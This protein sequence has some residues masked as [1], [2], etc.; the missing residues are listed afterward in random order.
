MKKINY[1]APTEDDYHQ[2]DNRTHVY[3]KAGM[4]IGSTSKE[5]RDEFVFSDKLNK[6][7]LKTIQFPVGAE[8]V[9]L[10]ILSNACDNC[11]KTMRAGIDC[12]QIEVTMN[13][14]TVIV[15]NYG[16][17]IPIVIKNGVN[18]YIPEFI[19][20]TVLCGSNLKNDNRKDIGTN[21]IGSKATNIMS[22]RFKV[23]IENAEY[24]KRYT[25]IWENNMLICNK[26][27]IEPYNGK[28]S[29]TEI[30]YDLDFK[31]FKYKKYPEEAFELFKKHTID[32]SF[33]GKVPVT[34]NNVQY[35]VSDIYDYG[36]LY[37]AV[38]N[39]IVYQKINDNELELEL[40]V[41]DS[42]DEGFDVAFV[43]CMYTS[44]GGVHLDAAYKAISD[45]LIKLINEK[46]LKKMDKNLTEKEKKSNLVTINDIKPH[47]SIILSCKVVN[48]E[49]DSQSKSKLTKPTPILLIE[50]EILKPIYEWDLIDRLYAAIDAKQYKK[51]AK[52][53]GKKSD[54]VE[55][56][57]GLD[58]NDAGTSTKS[59]D[60]VL[61]MIEGAS[62]VGYL[63]VYR[64]SI[65]NGTNQI[66][67]LPLKG[68]CLNV[69]NAK[70]KQIEKNAEI[71][72]LKLMLGL[73]EGVDYSDPSNFKNLR[74]GRIL[75]VTDA[76]VD[77]KH[78][79]GL[80]LN[81]F[82]C[83]F[84]G[85]L[86]VPGFITYK[87]TPIL[88]LRKGK[89]TKKFYS[90]REYEVWLSKNDVK[91]YTAEYFKG[92]GSSTKEDVKDD[93]K[94][95]VIV[96]CINDVDA[97]SAIRLAFDKN[98]RHER[99]NWI[100]NWVE[101]IDVDSMVN[102]PI[103]LFIHHEFITFSI[104]NLRRAIPG[105]DGNKEAHR[106][107]ICASYQHFDIN[108]NKHYKLERVCDL[109]GFISSKMQYHHGNSI[110]SKILTRM[111]QDF[112][113][114]NNLNLFFGKGQIG[115]VLGGPDQHASPRYL[116]TYPTE[117]FPYIYHPDDNKLTKPIIEQNKELEPEV[118]FTTIP[119]V[120]VNGTK[121]IATGFFTFVP[122]HNPLD[123][124]N[125]L[126]LR[127]NG[128]INLPSISPWYKDFKGDIT[129]V[130]RRRKNQRKT[131]YKDSVTEVDDLS[132]EED[133][134]SDSDKE[135]ID[136]S[137]DNY[138]ENLEDYMEKMTQK[139]NPLLSFD[140]T[141]IY[142]IDKNGNIIITELPIGLNPTLY[143]DKYLVPLI[144]KKLLK[145]VINDCT[146]DNIRF[147]LKGYIGKP[148]YKKLHLKKRYSLSNMVLLDTKNKPVKYDTANDLIEAFYQERLPI[149]KQRKIYKLDVLQ[150][151]IN[152]LTVVI[153][154]HNL[155]KKK[156]LI[157]DNVDKEVIYENLDKFDIPRKIYDNAKISALSKNETSVMETELE[158][159][160][161]EFATLNK[162][163]PSDIWMNDL[164]ALEDK[165]R[166][167]YKIK[168]K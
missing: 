88:R 25:Q 56:K 159:Y 74:Y 152:K 101:R 73:K 91:G 81:F 131:V 142:Y 119:M 51:L 78:I 84:P 140:V 109:D 158:G 145:K 128:A 116:E 115:N 167:V 67:I 35:N 153:K 44:R 82:Y 21:G 75:I 36:K 147:E 155:I 162:L 141:G 106:K 40:M 16:L 127:L 19:F 104:S 1:I 3:E 57:K 156:T 68:K 79:M 14:T 4:Y 122:N 85:L 30:S 17:S 62:P 15:K 150:N 154:F 8:R 135:S 148:S 121:G 61:C 94:D 60:C 89:Q 12:G 77:G 5:E 83:R 23:V 80:I 149:Y 29:S 100:L 108:F 10:E 134:E 93:L 50:D 13:N 151:K 136:E 146:D 164:N 32:I 11:C 34:F 49:F 126:K 55:L 144:K 99:K 120:L 161:K 132:F 18:K 124:I 26:E 125:W 118:Y 58:A 107:I 46:M 71:K 102:Q 157:V 24:K 123:I 41:I 95:E 2:F 65:P 111:S 96:T 110:I 90:Q 76:D 143:Y 9:F 133:E 160:K 63:Q 6:I 166:Q 113:N 163:K 165:Y 117:L 52:T 130:D 66:G 28:I 39:P 114:T 33:N 47:I 37:L 97:E 59:K 38:E 86:D 69:M 112:V 27:I 129:I 98:L 64:S 70:I 137:D 48:P 31:F 87:K 43:N 105:K 22:T 92:L 103:S 54:F 45:K 72:E 138:N 53:D 139:E 168:D 20:G 7:I 42:P